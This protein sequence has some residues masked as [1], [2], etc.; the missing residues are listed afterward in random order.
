VKISVILPVYNRSKMLMNALI[1]WLGQTVPPYEILV[2]DDG[3]DD[4]LELNEKV[5]Q[6]NSLAPYQIRYIRI[7]R[8]PAYQNSSRAYNVGIKQAK[9]D[10]IVYCASELIHFPENMRHIGRA[11]S[12][13]PNAFV[14][15]GTIFFQAE[16]INLP[17]GVAASP[18]KVFAVD[19]DVWHKEYYGSEDRHMLLWDSISG[20]HA[21]GRQHLIDVGGFEEALTSW[22]HND[23]HMRRRM[24]ELKGLP[25]VK[26]P[27]V[28]TVHPW[29]PRPPKENMEKATDNY[30]TALQSGLVANIG[31]DWGVA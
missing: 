29:H 10:F 22:G 24:T 15:G 2:V 21:V 19:F 26:L 31:R 11:L 13:N 30:N 12:K 7:E 4:G 18:E 25:E 28:I 1:S 20:V 9:G 23:G 3:S 14:V 6:A 27:Q 17:T 5:R 16:K 8:N